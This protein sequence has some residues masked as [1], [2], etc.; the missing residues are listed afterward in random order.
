MSRARQR[1]RHQAPS[2]APSAAQGDNRAGGEVVEITLT[3][4]AP[5]GEAIGRHAGMVLFVPYG[6]PGEIV[7]VRIVER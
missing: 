5:T 2:A 6:L 7:R 3:G 4:M 1:Q